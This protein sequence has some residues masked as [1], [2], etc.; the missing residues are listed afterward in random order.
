MVPV[1]FMDNKYKYPSGRIT[2]FYSQPS[3]ASPGTFHGAFSH[4]YQ[5]TWTCVLSWM[6]EHVLSLFLLAYKTVTFRR[7]CLVPVLRQP[8]KGHESIK[9]IT[10]KDVAPSSQQPLTG[11]AQPRGQNCWHTMTKAEK[12][13]PVLCSFF[14]SCTFNKFPSLHHLRKKVHYI[15]M[16]YYLICTKNRASGDLN[17]LEVLHFSIQNFRTQATE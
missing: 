4:P 1:E 9:T 16:N 11:P 12:P 7:G 2:A 6:T 17:S 13:V 10:W 3:W 15:T 5:K 14:H 8:R